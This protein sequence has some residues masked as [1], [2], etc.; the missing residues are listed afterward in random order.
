MADLR[1]RGAIALARRFLGTFDETAI[2]HK[3]LYAWEALDVMDV[4]E[5][6]QPQD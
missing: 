6:Y 3:V 1:P 4:I 2:G 5:Q